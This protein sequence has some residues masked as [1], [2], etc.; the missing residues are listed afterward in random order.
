MPWVERY[1]PWCLRWRTVPEGVE[2]CPVCKRI[3]LKE[4]P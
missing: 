4:K 3:G 2:Q 1:C